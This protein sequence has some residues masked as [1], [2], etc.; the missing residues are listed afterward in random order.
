MKRNLLITAIG[1][2]FAS[3][4]HASILEWT[5]EEALIYEENAEALSFRCRIATEDAFQE[6]RQEYYLPKDD[7][8]FVYLLML[9]REKRK[10]TYDYICK[11]PWDRVSNKKRLDDLYQDSIDVRLLPHNNKVAGANISI[12]LRLADKLKVSTENYAKIMSLGLNVTK[13]IRKDRNYNYDVEVMDSLRNILTKEQLYQILSSK[14]AVTC[15]NKGKTTWNELKNA[16]L[17][18]NE[19]SASCCEQAI[20]YYLTECIVNE[21]YIG[22]EKQ[23]QRNLS[24]LWK[25]QPLIVRMI[26]AV[27]KKEALAKKKE[28]NDNNNNNEMIW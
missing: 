12:S 2:F 1:L 14:H 6:L 3:I 24:D 19:D 25:R 5:Q 11:T 7:E 15:V 16:G 20:D 17:I 18:E 8:A 22:H 13:H 27:K 21:M 26:G 10:A 23:L 4:S 9:E 28:E